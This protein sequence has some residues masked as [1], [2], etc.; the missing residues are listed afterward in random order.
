ML[1][2]PNEK[3]YQGKELDEELDVTLY[4][5]EARFYDPQTG[6]FISV[7]PA[8]QF[9]SGYT[10]MGNHWIVGR[11]PDGKVWH[12]II[13]GLIGGGINVVMQAINGNIK[14]PGDFAVAFGIGFAAGAVTTMT[15][16]AVSGAM[17]GTG[18]WSGAVSS[19]A[20][21]SAIS[22]A[23]GFTQGFVAGGIGSGMGSLIETT[24]NAI[25]FHDMDFGD[26]LMQGG[27]SASMSLLT[28]GLI[29]GTANG[30]IAMGAGR[31]FLDG[32]LI[33]EE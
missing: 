18:F 19:T 28:G 12:I 1:R 17:M 25:A 16:G 27:Q 23:G 6:R 32:S 15:A 10:R 8:W 30:F 2:A 11:D 29:Q 13:G 4:N 31:S 14:G 5:F 26:A 22:G 21:S 9:F 3:L 33:M 20:A 7:D 24:G